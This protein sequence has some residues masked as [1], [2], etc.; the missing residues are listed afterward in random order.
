MFSFG[1]TETAAAEA[2][3][4]SVPIS[5]ESHGSGA[6]TEVKPGFGQKADLKF[7][8]SLYIF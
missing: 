3:P 8:K 4:G 7:G 1:S 6:S 2:S 5:T